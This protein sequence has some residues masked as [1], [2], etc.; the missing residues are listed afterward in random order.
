MNPL[1]ISFLES[2]F[3]NGFKY[4]LAHC[5]LYFESLIFSW[6][7]VIKPLQKVFLKEFRI[8]IQTYF[9]IFF[10]YGTPNKRKTNTS[11]YDYPTP[12]LLPLFGT[13]ENNISCF[14]LF[15]YNGEFLKPLKFSFPCNFSVPDALRKCA[16]KEIY[17][18]F[19]SNIWEILIFRSWFWLWL[20]FS[21]FHIFTAYFHNCFIIYIL[22]V[23]KCT[24]MTFNC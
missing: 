10:G 19:S 5:F 20:L 23:L 11:L 2:N 6:K 13:L 9:H 7:F 3:C 15:F 12:T 8:C 17:D 21:R 1:Q 4:D 14:L 18:D 24:T 16:S 22:N